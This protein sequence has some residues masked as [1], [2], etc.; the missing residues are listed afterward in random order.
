MDVVEAK[1]DGEAALRESGKLVLRDGTSPSNL[2]ALNAIKGAARGVITNLT[3]PAPPPPPPPPVDPPPPPPVATFAP[4]LFY[5]DSFA[6][7]SNR[8][9]EPMWQ[10]RGDGSITLVNAPDG[11]GDHVYALDVGND[12]GT[13]RAKPPVYITDN[14]RAEMIGPQMKPG[15]EL[16]WGGATWFPA[17][18]PLLPADFF[19]FAQFFGPPSNGSPPVCL[20]VGANDQVEWHRN[21]T[22]QWAQVWKRKLLRE[23]KNHWLIHLKINATVDQPGLV[24]MWWNGEKV[25][26]I[27]VPVFERASGEGREAARINQYRKAGIIQR[28]QRIYQWPIALGTKPELVAYGPFIL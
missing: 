2:A 6:K 13:P 24:E 27:K 8:L 23:H 5:G 4:D 25:C 14:P 3:D 19:G 9:N 17:D 21:V 28:I 10:P 1:K 7:F 11:S 16:W 22:G 20:Y 18:F 15:T 26:S 12:T